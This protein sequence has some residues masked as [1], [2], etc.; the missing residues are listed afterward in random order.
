[1][2][3]KF[4]SSQSL[5]FLQGCDQ[6]TGKNGRFTFFAQKKQTNKQTNNF[7]RFRAVLLVYAISAC[8]W[9]RPFSRMSI[10]PISHLFL[11]LVRS[12][13]STSNSSKPARAA[14][15]REAR[16]AN[17]QPSPAMTSTSK[18]SGKVYFVQIFYGMNQMN[19]KS[20]RR[21]S[22]EL[23]Q[24]SHQSSRQSSSSWKN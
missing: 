15:N 6:N 5:I 21:L 18:S 9:P 17:N 23:R 10:Q 11:L 2:A 8:W 13:A 22:D 1:M 14:A 7:G 3:N 12:W 16:A 24:S 19:W 20:I 4:L